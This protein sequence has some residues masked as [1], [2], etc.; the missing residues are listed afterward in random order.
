M[1]TELDIMIEPSYQVYGTPTSDKV[2]LGPLFNGTFALNVGA[3]VVK[4]PQVTLDSNA[5]VVEP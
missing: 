4:Q 2:I 5:V 1:S 3:H